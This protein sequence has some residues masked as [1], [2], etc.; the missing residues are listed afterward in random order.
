MK[1]LE[2]KIFELEVFVKSDFYKN[3]KVLPISEFRAVSQSRN[4]RASASDTALIIALN[5]TDEIIGFIGAL[6]EKIQAF[7]NLKI[8]WNSCWYVEP[9]KGKS[10]AMP[11]FYKFLAAYPDG[12]MM[13]DMTE[14]TKKI[15]STTGRFS[16]ISKLHGFNVF[17]RPI[18]AEILQRKFPKFSYIK[19]LFSFFDKST[20]TAISAINKIRFPYPKTLKFEQCNEIDS[21]SDSFLQ[22]HNADELFKRGKTELNWILEYPW[23]KQN[24]TEYNDLE[25]KYFFSAI[26]KRFDN[27]IIKLFDNKTG[28][29]VSVL[30][31][32]NTNG[33]YKI[34][35]SYFKKNRIF[36]ISGFVYAY[37]ISNKA[38]TLTLFNFEL[39]YAMIQ[40]KTPFI[41]KKAFSK[42][43]YVSK[44]IEQYIKPNFEFQ[45]GE[46]DY[47]FA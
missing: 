32:T 17:F 27:K 3:S 44:N 46:G 47:V 13:R 9:E 21:E 45:D 34:P 15:I 40:N 24:S 10:A 33:N 20:G 8:A 19:F 7:P 5:E 43:F 2:I 26:K 6:P 4:P 35:Y 36:E 31:F 37:L 28:E 30:F 41:F 23:I 38:I 18:S 22:E 16:E 12:V 39:K 14:T 11:L 29:L 42:E 1:F 25:K